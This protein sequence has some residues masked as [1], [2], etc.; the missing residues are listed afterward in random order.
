MDEHLTHFSKVSPKSCSEECGKALQNTS[1]L[2]SSASE[3]QNPATG[4]QR[5][6]PEQGGP[7]PVLRKPGGLFCPAAK[8]AFGNYFALCCQEVKQKTVQSKP[9]KLDPPPNQPGPMSSQAHGNSSSSAQRHKNPSPGRGE[10]H[11]MLNRSLSPAM[12]LP[13]QQAASKAES[14]TLH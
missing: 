6:Q 2:L 4:V 13:Q 8:R 3:E 14:Q 12:S 9:T 1:D 7:H 11:Q 10:C 5:I